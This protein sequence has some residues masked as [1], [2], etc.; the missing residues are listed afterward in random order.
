MTKPDATGQM[1]SYGVF[2]ATGQKAPG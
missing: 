2:L 1:R